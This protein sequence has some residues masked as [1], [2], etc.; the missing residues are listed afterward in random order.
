MPKIEVSGR[1]I[2]YDQQGSGEPLLLIP[3]LAADH[4]CYGFQVAEY[5]KSFTCISVDLYGTGESDSQD[6]PY[7]IE[8]FADTVAGFLQA[9]GIAKAHVSGLSLG[10]VVGM[11]L[12]S[13]YPETVKSLSL[14]SPWTRTDPFIKGVVESWQVM[15][16]ALDSV[17][18]MV[19]RA[20]FPWCFTAETYARPGFIDS[21]A[22]FVR[23]RP[24]AKV[25]TFVQHSNA[26]IAHDAE[27]Q[28]AD[29]KAPTQITFGRRDVLT[30]TRFAPILSSLIPNSEVVVFE[31]CSHAT[32]YESAGEF[33]ERTLAFLRLHKD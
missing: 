9:I 6:G 22:A 10:A 32:I 5:A 13:K 16:K 12:A 24:A 1:P 27:G 26:V 30:S 14:H 33:N 29:I 19:V 15:A 21:L 25:S 17:P 11:R 18:E 4:A 7:S 3:Y 2:D 31:E 20:M 8:V 23:S 28:L